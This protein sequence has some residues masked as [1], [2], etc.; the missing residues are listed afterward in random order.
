[1]KNFMLLMHDDTTIPPDEAAWGGYIESLI[2]TGGFEG[3]SSIGPGLCFRKGGDV[4]QIAKQFVG[5]MRIQASSLEEAATRLA[6]NPVFEA[7]G[8]VEIREL[9]QT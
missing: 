9:P 5:Y 4:P 1:M 8:T 3:G 2:T 6:G 7:G